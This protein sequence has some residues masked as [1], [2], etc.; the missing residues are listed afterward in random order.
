MGVSADSRE[1]AEIGHLLDVVCRELNDA[2][3][4]RHDSDR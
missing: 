2:E 1:I 4:R 3:L